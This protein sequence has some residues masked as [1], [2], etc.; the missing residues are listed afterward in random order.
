MVGVAIIHRIRSN[1]P[2]LFRP[3]APAGKT[4]TGR[5]NVFGDVR[6]ALRLCRW[7]FPLLTLGAAALA[8]S[9]IGG[10]AVQG[11]PT[12]VTV[13][14]VLRFQLERSDRADAV[15]TTWHR[16]GLAAV[17]RLGVRGAKLRTMPMVLVRGL[18]RD[19]LALL[20]ASPAVRS[21]WANAKYRVAM[22]DTTVDHTRALCVGEVE[23]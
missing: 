3:R 5:I 7:A 17:E 22:E 6:R 8:T 23:Q 9:G 16:S 10:A 2:L 18:T 20:T 1:P 15:V 12:T 4:L 11:T 19:Q 13:D 14:S 21:V